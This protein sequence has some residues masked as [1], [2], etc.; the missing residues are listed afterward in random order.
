MKKISLVFLFLFTLAIGVWFVSKYIQPILSTEIN[1]NLLLFTAGLIGIATVG[2]FICEVSGL[3][4]R[5][6]DIRNKKILEMSFNQG[7][8]DDETIERSTKNYIQPRCTNIDVAQETEPRHAFLVDEPLFPKIDFFLE[9]EKFGK[10]LFILADSGTGKT[11]CLLNY[12]AYNKRKPSRKQKKIVLIPLGLPNSD[13]LIDEIPNK[14]EKVLFLDAL[15]EDIEAIEDHIK[16][17]HELMKKCSV[18]K[19]VIITCRSQ[20][21]PSDEEIPI[22]TGIVKFRPLKA[23]EKSSYEFWKLYLTPFND[24]EIN[25]F[26]R[27]QYPFWKIKKREKAAEIIKKIPFLTVRPMLLAHIPDLVDRDTFI[28]YSFEL[29]DDMVDA[30]LERESY[31]VDKKTL[32]DF[33]ERIAV[34][35]YGKRQIRGMERIPQSELFLIADE[36]G[37]KIT[38]WQISGRSLLNRDALGNYKFAHRSIMEHLIIKRILLGDRKCKGFILTDQMKVFLFEQLQKRFDRKTFEF[39]QI[40]NSLNFKIHYSDKKC[41][42]SEDTNPENFSRS[43]FLG[44]MILLVVNTFLESN[45]I[46]LTESE[47]PVRIDIDYKKFIDVVNND[48]ENARSE[49]EIDFVKE[50]LSIITKPPFKGTH[51]KLK[52]IERQIKNL[53]DIKTSSDD[54]FIN[55]WTTI[56]NAQKLNKQYYVNGYISL[57][58][59]VLKYLE[60][61]NQSINIFNTS[62]YNKFEISVYKRSV[63]SYFLD[64]KYQI[65]TSS[66][67]HEYIMVFF[68]NLIEFLNFNSL[69]NI[70][71]INKFNSQSRGFEIIPAIGDIKTFILNLD[72]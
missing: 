11:S 8:F 38:H 69:E 42:K 59:E 72:L 34:N 21:F 65:S 29:Y 40:F 9:N 52:Y 49:I 66:V 28:T 32:R 6:D 18:F 51:S 48:L 35:I 47:R 45:H 39:E 70:L 13:L 30:W 1:N 68:E 60:L 55:S 63:I 20:F 50:L 7:P 31:W 37:M 19:R 46:I 53:P 2:S 67:I 71:L 24:Q 56:K 41:N 64:C 33:S 23:G 16:R 57:D 15:D 22:E 58:Q 4:D 12:F 14:K 25:L 54:E 62:I 61:S 26:L 10:H 44:R 3:F 17:V 36:W 43:F 5:F 27:K